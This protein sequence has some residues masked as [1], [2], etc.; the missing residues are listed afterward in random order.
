MTLTCGVQYFTYD[1]SEFFEKSCKQ[2]KKDK[3]QA[4]S[5]MKTH[6]TAINSIISRGR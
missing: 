2:D 1:G 4:E 3:A 6:E 5:D